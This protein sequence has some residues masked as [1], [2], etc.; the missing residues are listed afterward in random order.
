MLEFIQLNLAD[1]LIEYGLRVIGAILIFVVGQ[2]L[3]RLA[4]RVIEQGMGKANFDITLVSFIKNLAYYL[5]LA[6]VVVA[7]LNSL[8][9]ATTS[10]VAIL[11]ASALAVG[12]AL[13]GSLS[14]FAAGVMIILFRPFKVGDR[15]ETSGVLGDVETIQIFNTTVITL[16]NKTVIIPN[17]NITA[18][19]VVN[20][21]TK[22]VLRIDMIFGISYD[23]DLLKAK[24]VLEEILEK[25]PQVLNN[26]APTVA[27]MELAD[28]SVNFA[29]RPFVKTNDYW[30]V[31]FA[32]T[33]QVKLRFDQEAISIPYPQQ[34]LHIF[35]VNSA[36]PLP[37]VPTFSRG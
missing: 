32:L 16:D 10:L 12:L 6:A 18:D 29:V 2:W 23:D 37:E 31:Y 19:N 13:Q 5:L 30:D 3:A 34:D 15:I 9:V 4:T 1:F 17:A 35:G 14:N 36:K 24:H 22:G 27:V 28:S 7:A 25:H 26:P 21:S 8:G 11:G 33:E 20:Y